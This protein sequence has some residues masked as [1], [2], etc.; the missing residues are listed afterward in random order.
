MELAD[1][2]TVAAN[3]GKTGAT[4]ADGDMN[5]DQ[6]VTIADFIDTAAH[7]NQ[8]LAGEADP[9]PMAAASASADGGTLFAKTRHRAKVKHHH[10]RA[11]APRAPRVSD[12]FMRRV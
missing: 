1:F 8:S 6:Q 4:W 3:F 12:L 11:R 5:Y 9:I 10:K 2:I 7:F